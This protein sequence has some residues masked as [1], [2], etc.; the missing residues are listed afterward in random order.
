MPPPHD[1]DAWLLWWK[2]GEEEQQRARL[3]E[4]ADLIRSFSDFARLKG[5]VLEESAFSYNPKIGVVATAPGLT[6]SI[7][8]FGPD[9]KDGLYSLQRLSAKHQTDPSQPGYFSGE[10]YMLMVHPYFRRQMDIRNHFAPRF[11]DEFWGFNSAD[12]DQYI[13]ID[14]DRLRIDVDDS[15]YVEL[16][17]WFGPPFKKDVST[18]QNGLV[19]LRPPVDL[20]ESNVRDRFANAYC[21]D[22][23]WAQKGSIKSFQALELKTPEIQVKKG[24]ETF[25]PGRY[26]HAEFDCDK[27]LFRHFDGTIQLFTEDEYFRRRKS[28][29]RFNEKHRD[30]IKANSTKLFKF[31][32]PVDTDTWVNFCCQ[33]H[34]GN[35]LIY[36]YFAGSY[37]DHVEE[38]LARIRARASR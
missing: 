36:K 23:Q 18:V 3:S 27:G 14:G 6:A 25:F 38:G 35:S 15:S 21:V 37:P 22:I 5:V 4:A 13:A 2:E 10:N 12:V 9:D 29:F 8:G 28:D 7:L 30:Q 16:D 17:T 34:S 11:I 26:L 33:F 31:N 19:K 20:D 32:G 24:D 1:V